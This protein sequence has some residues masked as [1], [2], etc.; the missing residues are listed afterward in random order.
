MVI[1]A[2]Q[3]LADW[4]KYDK[5]FL[6]V[7]LEKTMMHMMDNFKM[8]IIQTVIMKMLASWDWISNSVI[9]CR[10]DSANLC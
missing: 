5:N 3:S 9:C 10:G 7:H 2:P 8:T 4:D 1:N 6:N